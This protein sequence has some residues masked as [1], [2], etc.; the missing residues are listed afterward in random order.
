ML[1]YILA[2]AKEISTWQ[3][4]LRLLTV[5]GVAISPANAERIVVIG[6]A[7]AEALGAILPNVLGA[8][9]QS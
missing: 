2:R 1:Q 8:K 7:V 3:S 4:I 9:V 6:V 5:A